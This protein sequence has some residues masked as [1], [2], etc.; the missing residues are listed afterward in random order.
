MLKCLAF[1]WYVLFHTHLAADTLGSASLPML[2]SVFKTLDIT[3]ELT[4]LAHFADSFIVVSV[5][6]M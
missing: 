5:A 6:C 3:L 2:L 4:F 1:V